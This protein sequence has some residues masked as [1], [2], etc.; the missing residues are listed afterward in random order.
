MQQSTMKLDISMVNWAN[1]YQHPSELV[2]LDE[3]LKLK[4]NHLKSQTCTNPGWTL[5]A[6]NEITESKRMVNNMR[7]FLHQQALH[8]FPPKN[9]GLSTDE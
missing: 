9:L 5:P 2:R 3:I 6:A 8:C 1:I 7:C 4:Q